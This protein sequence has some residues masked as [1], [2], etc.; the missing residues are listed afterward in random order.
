[1]KTQ[2]P[3]NTQINHRF[4]LLGTKY[5]NLKLIIQTSSLKPHKNIKEEHK[6][7]SQPENFGKKHN[8]KG[9]YI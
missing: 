6:H 7:S 8:N 3:K 1:M 2:L 4:F 9:D 5:K